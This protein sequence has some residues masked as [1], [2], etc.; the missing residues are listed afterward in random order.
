MPTLSLCRTP[1]P[2][3]QVIEVGDR[4]RCKQRD[5]RHQQQAGRQPRP[6][7][8]ILLDVVTQAAEQQGTRRA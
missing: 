8:I 2:S 1:S 5:G 6:S 7:A 3:R 4:R